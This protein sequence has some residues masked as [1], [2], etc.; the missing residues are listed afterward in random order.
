MKIL[1][2]TLISAMTLVA[3]LSIPT[4]KNTD[5]GV[6]LDE[7]TLIDSGYNAN[8][9]LLANSDEATRVYNA[10]SGDITLSSFGE[11]CK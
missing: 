6:Q 11:G 3:L 1:I 2:A 7:N 4:V 9:N 8:A 10:Q 5:C